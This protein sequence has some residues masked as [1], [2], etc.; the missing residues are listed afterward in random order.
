MRLAVNVKFLLQLLQKT[1]RLDELFN[2]LR[3]VALDLVQQY[4]Q[5]LGSGG[6]L[7]DIRRLIQDFVDF[8]SD[9]AQ[10][11][12]IFGVPASLSVGSPTDCALKTGCPL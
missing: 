11:V 8:R 3:P 9:N 5:A 12:E 4:L 1:L 6:F 2:G 10:L 7:L